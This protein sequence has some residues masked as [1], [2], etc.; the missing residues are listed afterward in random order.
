MRAL[1]GKLG[2]Q[3][4]AHANSERAA[5][6]A[7]EALKG[8]L[9]GV[10]LQLATTEQAAQIE[11]GHRAAAEAALAEWK[12]ASPDS[13]AAQTMPTTP[14][15][16]AVNLL[17]DLQ[18]ELESAKTELASVTVAAAESRSA[19]EAE[20]QARAEAFE[21]E[22][23]R[24]RSAEADFEIWR[25]QAQ[26][27]GQALFARCTEQ[28]AI[29]VSLRGQIE[30]ASQRPL[31]QAD[32]GCQDELM[33]LDKKGEILRSE[34]TETRPEAMDEPAPAEPGSPMDVAESTM[35]KCPESGA[36]E[37]HESSEQKLSVAVLESQDQE[38]DADDEAPGP[39][40]FVPPPWQVVK[41]LSH[42]DD[43]YRLLGESGI[44]TEILELARRLKQE[45]ENW[46]VIK[47]MHSF[48]GTMEYLVGTLRDLL[49]GWSTLVSHRRQLFESLLRETMLLET[50]QSILNFGWRSSI[51][52][53]PLAELLME[54][55]NR[56][57]IVW[58]W[59]PR[60][61]VGETLRPPPPPIPN[62]AP[63][64]TP[65]PSVSAKRDRSPSNDDGRRR[66]R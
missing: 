23:Q 66:K 1:R 26:S 41:R 47:A 12:A 60:Q 45:F 50:I 2:R 51:V 3:S 61:P 55:R 24:R 10:R 14:D 28:E 42:G 11:L 37:D 34:E 38:S 13:T 59:A 8:E 54:T 16:N 7:L 31:E 62:F 48:R 53:D 6:E 30:Q 49:K 44:R 27:E 29:I 9:E 56:A 15:G 40:P 25:A 43:P 39:G 18:G 52:G 46:V 33:E 5:S 19:L 57:A 36:C 4:D 58:D 22:L 64:A 17:K 65:L 21:G 63:V 35:T 32:T 20:M